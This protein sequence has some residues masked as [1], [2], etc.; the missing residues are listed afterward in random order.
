VTVYYL[1]ASVALSALLGHSRSAAIWIDQVTAQDE[2]RVVSSRI[3]RTELTRVL[4]R[5]GLPV[6]RR[7]EVLDALDLVPVTE[8]VLAAAEAIESHVK[9]L[10]AIHLGSVIAA[11]LDA[12]IVSH[13]ITMLAAATS[14][15]Y[16]S[17]DPVAER[18]S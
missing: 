5:E 15:G 12:T 4:R 11:G 14:L 9:T 18:A 2:H 16:P 3:L 1:D 8:A 10:D 7:E 17:L 6:S 13:D